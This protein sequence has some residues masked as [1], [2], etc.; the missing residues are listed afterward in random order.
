MKVSLAILVF[1]L[2]ISGCASERYF[3]GNG[4]EALIYEENHEFEIMIKNRDAIRNKLTSLFMKTE[5]LDR[6]AIYYVSYKS[7]DIKYF[8]DE[9]LKKDNK[10]SI[11][12]D[13]ISYAEDLS[14]KGDLNIN[15]SFRKIKIQQCNPFEISRDIAQPDCFVESIRLKSV[16]YKSR[17]VGA[18]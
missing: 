14:L 10:Y 12:S 4:V 9:T 18:R 2:F 11:Y 8:V 13:R 17:L 6:E 1:S 5:A 16:S 7:E 15:V 3:S